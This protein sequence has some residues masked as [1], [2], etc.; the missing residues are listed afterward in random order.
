MTS[1]DIQ[2]NAV[3]SALNKASR[4][5]TVSHRR[6][7]ADTLGAA[8]ALADLLEKRGKSVVCYS[9]DPVPQSLAR[10]PN[11]QKFTSDHNVLATVDV[12]V[13]L[14]ASDLKFAG[15]DAVIPSLSPRPAIINIDHHGA[16]ENFGDVNLVIPTAASTTEIIFGV[17]ECFGDSASEDAATNMLA[18]VIHD[19]MMFFN[20]ATTAASLGTASRLEALGADRNFVSRLV[21]RNKSVE[22]LSL[23]GKA[24]ERLKY[25]PAAG[26]VSTVLYAEETSKFNVDEDSLGGLSNFLNSVLPARVVVVLRENADGTIKGSLRTA[27]ED[28][29]VAAEALRWG[30]GGHRKAAGFVVKGKIVERDNEWGVEVE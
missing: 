8:L 30:G 12:I 18:G 14:D 4:V 1:N 9:K 27:R 23:W 24:L 21:V 7:D 19:T 22:S 26:R 25:D 28:T 10:L 6:P 13:V 15:V 11:S 3:V 5:A 16:N 20:P 29:D 2:F 17:Y